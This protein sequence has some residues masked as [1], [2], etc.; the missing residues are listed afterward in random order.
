MRQKGA[1]HLRVY[2]GLLAV[3]PAGFRERY[4]REMTRLFDDRYREASSRG[5]T[6]FLWIAT[7]WDVIYSSRTSRN[8]FQTLGIP[9]LQGRDFT[10]DDGPDPRWYRQR[11][12]SLK[13]L[14]E[15]NEIRSQSNGIG[16]I[17]V[18]VSVYKVISLSRS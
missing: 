9:L 10:R 14:T 16:R 18:C 8:H 1:W 7:L 12:S 2:Q 17:I 13:F 5:R 4:E 6:A 15:E 3:Y 11:N